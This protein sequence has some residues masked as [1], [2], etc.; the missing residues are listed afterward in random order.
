MPKFGDIY[1]FQWQ[2]G[3]G[4]RLFMYICPDTGDEDDNGRKDEGV[5]MGVRLGNENPGTQ[6]TIPIDD[7]WSLVE[8]A[9]DGR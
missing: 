4:E 7:R 3:A 1:R 8:E 5:W 9:N 2:S 6:R